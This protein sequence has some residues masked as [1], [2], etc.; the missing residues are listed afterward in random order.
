[1]IGDNNHT[2]PLTTKFDY[3][4]R[5]LKTLKKQQNIMKTNQGHTILQ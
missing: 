4:V 3:G 5:D 1:M 2:P